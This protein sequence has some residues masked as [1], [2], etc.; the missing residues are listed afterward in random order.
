MPE[1]PKHEASKSLT[2]DERGGLDKF[3]FDEEPFI[4]V[5]TDVCRTC[6]TKP[7]LYV[8]PSKV[9]RLEKGELVYNTEGCIELGACAIVCKHLGKDAIHWSYPRGSYGVEFRFGRW[10]HCTPK[11]VRLLNEVVLN[12]RA[13]LAEHK[14]EWL[15]VR[16]PSGENYAHLKTLFRSLDLHTVCEE[17]HCPNV[18]ECWGGGT[19]TIMLMGDTCTRGCRFCAVTSGNPHGVLDLDE[20]KKVAMA[21]AEMDLTYVVLTSVDRDDLADGGAGH[22]AKT[23]REI[24]A[25]RPDM[26]VETL[27]PDFQGDLE[28]VRVIVDS[29]VDVLDHNIETVERLQGTVRD[30]RAGYAQS[31]K[32]LRGAKEMRPELFTKSSIMLGLGETRA[33]V[34]A[35][36]RDLR[37][38]GVDIVTVGQYLRPSTW[39]LAVQEYVPPAVFDELRVAGESMGFAYVAAGPLVRS[40]YRAGEFFLEKVLRERKR[41]PAG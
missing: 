2:V 7:C 39:H 30:R 21:L 34:L 25:R 31:L 35:A 27:I 1:P 41:V 9:Y 8:C 16:P 36:M 24:K 13:M 14:P 28:A 33:E 37:A 18:W 23:V 40:S 4:T 15:R 29:G 17:A 22:F 10:H 5:D 3:E 6:D 26:L 38:N 32:V 20:P 11:W 19:A 12:N